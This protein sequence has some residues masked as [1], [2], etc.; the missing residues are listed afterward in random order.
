MGS[1]TWCALFEISSKQAIRGEKLYYHIRTFRQQEGAPDGQGFDGVVIVLFRE[2]IQ[3]DGINVRAGAV[4]H[5]VVAFACVFGT[6][7]R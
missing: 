7:L 6:S 5:L 2:D 3:Q 4:G 1:S